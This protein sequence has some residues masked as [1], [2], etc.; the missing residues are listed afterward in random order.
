MNQ[1][2]GRDNATRIIV[3]A[4]FWMYPTIKMV[5]GAKIMLGVTH[6]LAMHGFI[7]QGSLAKVRTALAKRH[8]LG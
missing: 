1:S 5:P 3:E 8:L 4:N 7:A 6:Q 2:L